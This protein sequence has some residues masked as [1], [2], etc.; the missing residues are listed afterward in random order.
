MAISNSK[1]KGPRL[2]DDSTHAARVEP[3]PP[4]DKRS[5]DPGPY[6]ISI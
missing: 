1:K 3:P 2:G 6:S 5:D 4:G